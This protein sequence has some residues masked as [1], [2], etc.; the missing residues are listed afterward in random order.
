LEQHLMSSAYLSTGIFLSGPWAIG[1]G[2]WNPH[3][4]AWNPDPRN[5]AASNP[6]LG[7]WNPDPRRN[8]ASNPHHG[9]WNP[10][11][12]V[13]GARLNPHPIHGA[14]EGLRPDPLESGMAPSQKRSLAYDESTRSPWPWRG[15]HAPWTFSG[16]VAALEA[17]A[18]R[19]TQARL[20]GERDVRRAAAEPGQVAQPAATVSPLWRWGSEF[21]QQAVVGELLGRVQ[22]VGRELHLV[23]AV[24]GSSASAT[25]KTQRLLAIEPSP[26]DFGE[27]ID[28]VLRAA[29]EREERLPEILSQMADFRRFYYAFTPLNQL[30][31]RRVDELLSV[32]WAWATHVIMMLKDHIAERRPVER[33]A[34]VVPVIATPAHGSLPSGHAT[35]AMMTACLLPDLLAWPSD[36]ARRLLLLRLAGRI[37]FNRVVAGVHY[38]IDSHVGRHLG[39]VLANT[40]R[41]L[42]GDT[43]SVNP[44]HVIALKADDDWR[45]D[46]MELPQSA[47][48]RRSSPVA[49]AASPSLALMWNAARQEL[50]Q[51]QLL[52]PPPQ[53]RRRKASAP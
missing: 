23:S 33:S 49:T 53:R 44:D 26:K 15:L 14:A 42:A 52:A 39:W 21:R 51:L 35:I 7:A 22:V 17:Q 38:P 10:D 2:E 18:M 32:A 31:A 5:N 43:T 8:A 9:G 45:E 19:K 46:E 36:D 4:G 50:H 27:Q 6:H 1:L 48:K 16:D 34:L 40:F 30:P 11:P 28:R 20:V 37:A 12:R 24:G 3:H 47:A 25:L 29:V 41:A 13:D